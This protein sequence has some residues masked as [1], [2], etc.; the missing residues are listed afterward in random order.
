MNLVNL[1]DDQL[2]SRTKLLAKQERELLTE[3]LHHLAEVDRRRLF[4]KLQFT[5]LFDYAVKELGY[6]EDQAYRRISAAR[7]LNQLPEIEHKIQDGS[8]TLASL[9]VATSAMKSSSSKS[10]RS[11]A[12]AR[13]I[14]SLIEGKSKREAESILIREQLIEAHEVRQEKIRQVGD[15]VEIRLTISGEMAT[16]IQQLKSLLAHSHPDFSTADLFEKLI[17]EKL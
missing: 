17:E 1:S 5:S 12:E 15:S 4:S 2:I 9:S 16:K 10:K 13:K 7:L 14:V 6:S 8:L 11:I 3:V